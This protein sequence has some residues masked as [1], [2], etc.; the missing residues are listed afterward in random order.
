[1]FLSCWGVQIYV[2]GFQNYVVECFVGFII[3]FLSFVLGG[4]PVS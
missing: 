4:D 2:C 3:M 1:M